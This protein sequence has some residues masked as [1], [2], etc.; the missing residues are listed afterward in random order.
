M[1]SFVTDLIIVLREGAV[2]EQGTHEELLRKG[3]LYTSMWHE[4][5][6]DGGSSDDIAKLEDEVQELRAEREEAIL[7]GVTESS[8]GTNVNSKP[9]LK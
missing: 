9:L 1:F 7:A 8:S 3:G 6:L 5:A 2:V 4:Q